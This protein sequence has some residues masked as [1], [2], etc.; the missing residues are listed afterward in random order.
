MKKKIL[1]TG[2]KG[3]IGTQVCKY[4]SEKPDY[5]VVG[6]D[7]TVDLRSYV[8]IFNAIKDHD[9][10]HALVHT[11]ARGG[12]RD[13]YD[14]EEVSFNNKAAFVNLMALKDKFSRIINLASGAEMYNPLTPYGES[15]KWISYKIA[16]IEN[17]FSL[18]IFNVFHHTELAT[19]FIRS[20]VINYINN[21][22][23]VVHRNRFMD[24]FYM[25][26]FLHVLNEYVE[27]D[28]HAL[29]KIEYCS[30][31]KTHTLLE[32]AEKINKLS[33]YEV[34][35]TCLQEGLDNYYA[36]PK[37]AVV[38]RYDESKLPYGFD[39]GLMNVYKALKA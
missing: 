12:H 3:Y 39:K 8:D 38:V 7:N 5:E 32:V 26:D 33:N 23:I 29:K 20:N 9:H 19:R 11:A 34:D 25:G 13:S 2:S 22:P 37:S 30:Y 35:I 4:F 36:A 21:E 6:L 10:F 15:K 16:E 24:F 17:A 14:T 1:V 18:M 28:P 27:N 31:E